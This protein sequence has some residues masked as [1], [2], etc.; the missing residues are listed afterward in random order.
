[1]T[2]VN[3]LKGV[4]GNLIALQKAHMTWPISVTHPYLYLVFV[5]LH[6]FTFVLQDGRGV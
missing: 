2:D 1:M 5:N 6:M 4:V 3:H